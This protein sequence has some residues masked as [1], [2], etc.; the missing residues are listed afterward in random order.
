MNRLFSWPGHKADI[1]E[2]IQLLYDKS[3]CGKICEG[4]AGS[5]VLSLNTEALEFCLVDANSNITD[6]FKHLLEDPQAVIS[7]INSHDLARVKTDQAYFNELREKFNNCPPGIDRSALFWVIVHSSTNNLARFNRKGEYNQT[8]GRRSPIVERWLD[9]EALEKL[10][11][12]KHKM[13]V[14]HGSYQQSESDSNWFLYLDPPYLLENGTYTANSWNEGKERELLE[15]LDSREQPW[16]LSN[17]MSR[18][19]VVNQL[20]MDFSNKYRTINLQK[21]YRARVGG[22]GVATQEIQEVL[23]TN[24]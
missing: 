16:A 13:K 20:L 8:W 24:V 22:L 19:G 11:D 12:M 5:A 6:L 18:K 23:I 17:V 1:L 2:T 14:I 9:K 21:K 15:W 7:S 3:C 4:F 10:A